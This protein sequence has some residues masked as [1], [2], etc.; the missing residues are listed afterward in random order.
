MGLV[1]HLDLM[2]DHENPKIQIEIDYN[3]EGKRQIS[4]Q[5]SGGCLVLN[6]TFDDVYGMM[7]PL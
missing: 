7:H 4:V 6:R 2:K 5:I 1:Q 3:K